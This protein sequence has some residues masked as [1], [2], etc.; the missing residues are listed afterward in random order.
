MFLPVFFTNFFSAKLGGTTSQMLLTVKLLPHYFGNP[1]LMSQKISNHSAKPFF[2]N[3]NPSNKERGGHTMK[4][5]YF[6]KCR[7]I[8]WTKFSPLSFKVIGRL[9][10]KIWCLVICQNNENNICQNLILFKNYLNF[11]SG[12]LVGSLIN[13]RT[14]M[15]F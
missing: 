9:G 5:Q 3:L 13:F 11:N 7:K 8:F 2:N 10:V 14:N 1:P 12:I 6:V 4:N 15:K